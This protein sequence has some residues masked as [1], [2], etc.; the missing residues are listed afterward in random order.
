MTEGTE[1]FEHD[2]IMS[3]ELIFIVVLLAFYAST[4]DFGHCLQLAE[5]TEN[6]HRPSKKEGWKS[7]LGK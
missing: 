2:T 1:F 7:A 4:L 5:N 6:P 3:S